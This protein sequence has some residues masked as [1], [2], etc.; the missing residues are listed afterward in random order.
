MIAKLTSETCQPIT[1]RPKRNI[2]VRLINI[3]RQ[4][5]HD[6]VIKT[7]A[8]R[9]DWKPTKVC[10]HRGPDFPMSTSVSQTSGQYVN[11]V[12]TQAS[13]LP[14]QQSSSCFARS[15]PWGQNKGQ[16]SQSDSKRLTFA[17]FKY[18]RSIAG[19]YA[20]ESCKQEENFR[21]IYQSRMSWQISGPMQPRNRRMA[22]RNFNS[23][24]K[25]QIKKVRISH[26][27]QTHWVWVSY[28]TFL[29]RNQDFENQLGEH[30]V[31]CKKNRM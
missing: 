3:G 20:H 23:C 8:A 1:D 31:S 18:K 26:S 29:N 27:L 15:K 21:Q 11:R 12:S 24:Q 25:Q 9:R 19:R 17:N 14:P 6:I 5:N 4:G 22:R 10:H 16:Q 30:V 2:T 13:R 28:N 7:S